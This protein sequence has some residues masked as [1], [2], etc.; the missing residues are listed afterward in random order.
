MK[1][2]FRLLLSASAIA[3]FAVWRFTAEEP[4]DLRQHRIALPVD[5]KVYH[6]LNYS[7]I[8][9]HE[10]AEGNMVVSSGAVAIETGKYTGRSPKDKYIVKQ[11]PSE[12][13]VIL[14]SI[15]DKFTLIT[16]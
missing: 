9:D 3:L 5:A 2:E 14:S 8:F 13:E 15:Y 7:D 16:A 4:V 10:T 12:S 1:D 11:P 6:N